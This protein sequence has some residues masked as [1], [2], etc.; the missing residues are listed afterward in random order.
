LYIGFFQ[1]VIIKEP[2]PSNRPVINQ[3]FK[4]GE[5]KEESLTPI[6]P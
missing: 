4:E 5:Q 1:I 6:I 3:G 2:S